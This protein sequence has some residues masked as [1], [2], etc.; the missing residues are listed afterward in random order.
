MDIPKLPDGFY[1][2]TSSFPSDFLAT[3][4]NYYLY[5]YDKAMYS[6]RNRDEKYCIYTA[7]RKL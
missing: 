5:L 4:V 7:D 6:T 3:L 1:T 2:S